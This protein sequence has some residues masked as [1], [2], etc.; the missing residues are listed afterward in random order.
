[1]K[2]PPLWMM[3]PRKP[4][5]YGR[6]PSHIWWNRRIKMYIL[7]SITSPAYHLPSYHILYHI[8]YITSHISYISHI[9]YL[10]YIPSIYPPLIIFVRASKCWLTNPA[11]RVR[12]LEEERARPWWVARSGSE[13]PWDTEI[14][15][16]R[17][18]PGMVRIMGISWETGNDFTSTDFLEI[19]PL[20]NVWFFI[21]EHHHV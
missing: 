18:P 4:H 3:F 1:M 12:K 13:D 9:W 16:L 8:S 5:F 2:H 7:Y 20:V 21:I 11:D 19:S 17:R 14:T 10:C 15:H 6:F